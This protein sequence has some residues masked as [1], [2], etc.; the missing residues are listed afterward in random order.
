MI[1]STN[2]YAAPDALTPCAGVAAPYLAPDLDPLIRWTFGVGRWML[3]VQFLDYLAPPPDPR[4][5]VS[6]CASCVPV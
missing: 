6:R 1:I 3:D 5:R 2:V 4:L